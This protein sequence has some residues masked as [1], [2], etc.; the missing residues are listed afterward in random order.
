M[1][2]NLPRASD[3]IPSSCQ[4]YIHA[5]E[6]LMASL[7]S[8]VNLFEPNQVSSSVTAEESVQFIKDHGF[9]YQ[10]DEN[11]GKLVDD[12]YANGRARSRDARLDHFKPTLQQDSR[13]RRILD[14]Y[15]ME[16][17]GLR[18]PW[19][20]T[21]GV[22]YNWERKSGLTVE[23]ALAAYMLGSDSQWVCRD[24]SHRLGSDGELEAIGVFGI[25]NHLLDGYPEREIRMERGGILLV[26]TRLAHTATRGRSIVLGV[27]TEAGAQRNT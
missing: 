22:Y 2:S 8:M 6:K 21:P 24:G 26:R 10:G 19:G 27:L 4:P 14:H 1:T 15:P 11:I 23:N 16:I 12:M 5:A 18:F 20:T 25:Q 9:F 13:L 3:L 17:P 7:S